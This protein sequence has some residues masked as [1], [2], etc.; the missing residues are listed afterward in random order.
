MGKCTSLVLK[1]THSL[2]FSNTNFT[3]EDFP[4]D[5]AAAAAA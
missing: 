3:Q 2:C 5:D 1:K 4:A